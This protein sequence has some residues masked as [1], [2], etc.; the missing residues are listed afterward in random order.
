MSTAN[1]THSYEGIQKNGT[2]GSALKGFVSLL[3]LLLVERIA[4]KSM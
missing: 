2:T 4:E 1:V 3:E